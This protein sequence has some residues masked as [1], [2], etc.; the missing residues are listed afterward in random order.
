V[1]GDDFFSAPISTKATPSKKVVDE[2]D[3]FSW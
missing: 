3:F 1:I 2:D